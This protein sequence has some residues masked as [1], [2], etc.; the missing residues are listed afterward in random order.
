MIIQIIIR[1]KCQIRFKYITEHQ[2][3]KYFVHSVAQLTR[4]FVCGVK[5]VSSFCLMCL[6]LSVIFF[7]VSSASISLGFS[8]SA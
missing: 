3:M 5:P 7:L 4:G 8:S 6:S 2:E 1:D